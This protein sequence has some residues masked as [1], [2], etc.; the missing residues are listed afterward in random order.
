MTYRYGAGVLIAAIMFILGGSLA[1]GL[2]NRLGLFL[3]G[4]AC[5]AILLDTIDRLLIG[6]REYLD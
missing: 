1:G 5:L 2:F 4:G 6:E 3:A